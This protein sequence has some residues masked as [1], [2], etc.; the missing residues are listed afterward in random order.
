MPHRPP[1]TSDPL[2]RSQHWG[3]R[4]GGPWASQPGTYSLHGHPPSSPARPS[5]GPG[6]AHLQAAS[7]DDA[8][9][10][11]DAAARARPLTRAAPLHAALDRVRCGAALLDDARESALA[12]R[13]ARRACGRGPQLRRPPCQ[14]SRSLRGGQRE[15]VWG[16]FG[17]IHIFTGLAVP[18]PAGPLSNRF[19]RAPG[20]RARLPGYGPLGYAKRPQTG[21]AGAG[22]GPHM[23]AG[24]G[25]AGRARAGRAG[26]EM[27]ILHM[28]VWTLP[29]GSIPARAPPREDSGA[30]RRRLAAGPPASLAPGSSAAD[31]EREREGI[32]ESG[33]ASKAGAEA[34]SPPARARARGPKPLPEGRAVAP[35]SA[36]AGGGGQRRPGRGRSARP[37]PINPSIPP[38]HDCVRRAAAPRSLH[39]PRRHRPGFVPFRSV[40]PP[41]SPWRAA[42]NAHHPISLA[43]AREGEGA[44]LRL[45]GGV[46]TPGGRGSGLRGLCV[47]PGGTG[48]AYA[49]AH[50]YR[51]K[52]RTARRQNALPHW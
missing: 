6:A 36:A 46:V 42:P 20:G 14:K 45:P 34:Q 28:E 29:N 8:A 4:S 48:W 21:A 33:A 39:P 31:P 11:D 47:R 50:T 12:R 2:Y 26:R 40:P 5:E 19:P 3:P 18:T 37:P 51:G 1:E 41:R 22:E 17:D 52:G 24:R 13:P 49:A 44:R 38:I 15:T 10:G 9:A 27:I 32:Q 43:A 25:W 23:G 7:M 35:L 30:R 16:S